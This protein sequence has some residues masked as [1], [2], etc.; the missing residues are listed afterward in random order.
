MTNGPE[1]YPPPGEPHQPPQPPQAPLGEPTRPLGQPWGQ[2][3]KPAAG[4]WP[5][6]TPAPAYG[7]G[8][9]PT[10]A[11]QPLPDY[12]G[13]PVPHRRSKRKPVLLSIGTAILVLIGGGAFAAY[14][15]LDGGGPQPEDALPGNVVGY[16]E[17]DLDPGAGQ[18]INAFRL[19]RK[20]PDAK[21][22]GEDSLKDDLL[23]SFFTDMDEVDYDKDIKPWIGDRAGVAFLDEL[24]EDEEPVVVGAIQVTDRKRAE[25]S[26]QRLR[27][28]DDEEESGGYAFGA[29]GYVVVAETQEIADRA[30]ADAKRS[31][32]TDNKRYRAALDELGGDR[33][34]V[35]W[36]DLEGIFDL[37]PQEY[38]ADAGPLR[39]IDP[40]GS[41]IVG[42]QVKPDAVEI[43]GKGVGIDLG[44]YGSSSFTQGNGSLVSQLPA[45]S[46]VGVS[47]VGLGDQ[48]AAAYDGIV[49]A[50]KQEPDLAD[51]LEEAGDIGLELPVDIT[52]LLGDET[53]AV[54]LPGEDPDQPDV[55]ARTRGG[56]PD[57][58]LEI[59]QMAFAYFTGED[60][61]DI[62]LDGVV[63]TSKD[64]LLAAS[65]PEL[66]DQLAKD[67]RLGSTDSFKNAVA[68]GDAPNVLFVNLGQLFDTYG[69]S[70]FG[71]SAAELK[72]V[73][74]LDA[75]GMSA[76]GD[77]FTVRITFR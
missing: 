30:V 46:I 43:N 24:D 52:A 9:V 75:V 76:E 56:D 38:L 12:L 60:P 10:D 7:D 16:A 59:I 15:L 35:A 2:P 77:A 62:P 4:D 22:T 14:S 73:A 28:E 69:D 34:A 51:V 58:G 61:A 39:D 18:K 53:A 74:P 19:A 67:G 48:L 47:I 8:S 57:R 11:T 26:I 5:S 49:E 72:N 64:G 41:Y 44:K 17:I 32:L 21:V 23:R 71:L 55:G 36:A 3:T 50:S 65:S 31:S 42:A 40:K 29:D 27:D 63:E 25:A 20:F 54:L 6:S 45:D 33:V 37:I 13:A 68:D 1:G 66:L 70:E